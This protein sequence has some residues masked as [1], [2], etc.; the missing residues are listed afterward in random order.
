MPRKRSREYG[1]KNKS[2]SRRFRRI[3]REGGKNSDYKDP[4]SKRARKAVPQIN[5]DVR[6]IAQK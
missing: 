4:N 5:A 6:R 1:V 3:S 2:G